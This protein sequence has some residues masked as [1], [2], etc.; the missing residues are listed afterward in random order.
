MKQNFSNLAAERWTRVAAVFY[1]AWGIVHILG[2]V[3]LLSAGTGEPAQ[4]LRAMATGAGNDA[5]P[6]NPGPVVSALFAYHAFNLLWLGALVTFVAVRWNWHG[7]QSGFWLNLF[8][9]G[10]VDLGL[11]AT[12]IRPGYIPV[13]EG[14]IGVTLFV[15]AA[16]CSVMARY[17]GRTSVSVQA[18]A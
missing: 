8:V 5:I 4:A 9:V 1:A 3:M 16:F 6:A 7:S 15:A 10:M 12:M 17:S 2:G 13:S 14:A 18:A 11:V